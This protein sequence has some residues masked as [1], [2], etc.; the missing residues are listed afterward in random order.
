MKT[1]FAII[2]LIFF[3]FQQGKNYAGTSSFTENEVESADIL[4]RYNLLDVNTYSANS[5]F[6]ST[7]PIQLLWDGGTAEGV[8]D[9]KAT[10]EVEAWIEF[11]FGK[12]EE[13]ATA[14]LW[15]DNGGNR[16]T[17]WKVMSW[18][19]TGWTDIFPYVVANTA[20]W[21]SYTF[22]V[23]T[24]K[25]RFYAKC[26][27]NGCVSIHEIELF[28]KPSTEQKKTLIG[29]IGDSNTYGAGASVNTLYA[30]PIQLCKILGLDYKVN[31]LGVSGTTLQSAPADKPWVATTQYTKH[32]ELN[33]N[34]S[35]IALG[36]N[37]SK[38]YNW[39]ESAPAHFKSNYID[40]I[41]EIEGYPSNPDV[42]ML[43]PI[44]AFS[45]NYNINNTV[46]DNEIRPIVRDISKTYGI[47]LIDGYSATENIGNLVPDGIHL[48]DEGLKILA[49]KVASILQTKKPVITVNGALS[50]TTY[51]EYRWYRDDI[52]I[53]DA[54]TST[55][56]A[57]QP[58][59][60]KVAVKLSSET[61]D[62]IVS[63]NIEVS[64]TNVNLVVSDNFTNNIIVPDNK[65][66]VSGSSNYLFIENLTGSKFFLL[67]IC[68]KPVKSMIIQSSYDR[69]DIS[70]L[71]NGV[72]VYMVGES[73]GKILK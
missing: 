46:I 31:N 69:I 15:Q 58:G 53:S 70:D 47:A 37:D 29:C 36:T 52:L 30:W 34:I 63:N 13:I 22:D 24:T 35:I 42:Y 6:L 32:K 16:V 14:R 23:K 19:G 51:T 38:S 67:D 25:V 9:S 26:A 50:A 10:G 17:H 1:K 59:I 61:D 56:T 65:A 72:Y 60:Y 7:T 12:E 5:G 66:K 3:V 49:E 39:P 28:T 54:A 21:Q 68:G 11:D 71:S 4:Y 33:T 43:M 2:L 20:G 45:G 57:T 73:K 64:G 27:T 40:L 8:N 44:K 41:K 55:Y 18:T 62:I 48:N